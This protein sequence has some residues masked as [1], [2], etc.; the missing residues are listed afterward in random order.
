MLPR[1]LVGARPFAGFRRANREQIEPLALDDEVG[2][3][4]W[5]AVGKT[6]ARGRR[7]TAV[8]RW[9]DQRK[10]HRC[11]ELQGIAL[12]R[13]RQSRCDRHGR[14]GGIGGRWQRHLQAMGHAGA[15]RLGQL[16]PAVAL[17]RLLLAQVFRRQQPAVEKV[18]RPHAV[19]HERLQQIGHLDA[20]VGRHAR[21][22]YLINF[23][24][25]WLT[26][27]MISS[28]ARR[29]SSSGF[30]AVDHRQHQAFLLEALEQ[31][32]RRRQVQ[33]LAQ[34]LVAHYQAP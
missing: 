29:S 11:D 25:Y 13:D 5:L 24:W 7:R 28:C 27:I 20:I 16:A 21:S 33:L 26:S 34:L 17:G 14:R 10:L 19:R 3:R 18:D 4:G 30:I 6:A 31:H 32:N 1:P 23:A 22:S 15:Q 9:R 12:G 2:R 8:G